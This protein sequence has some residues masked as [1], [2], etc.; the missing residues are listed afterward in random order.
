MHQDH[1]W[2]GRQAAG[3]LAECGAQPEPADHDDDDGYSEPAQQ[4]GDADQPL[5]LHS[6]CNAGASR[7]A[8]P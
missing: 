3:D 6:D 2:Q 7:W 4:D 8:W 5:S 1:R